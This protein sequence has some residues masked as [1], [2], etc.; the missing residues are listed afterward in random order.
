MALKP[1][2]TGR[3]EGYDIFVNGRQRTF[4]DVKSVAY[5][6]AFLLKSANKGQD[7][8]EIVDRATGQLMQVTTGASKPRRRARSSTKWASSPPHRPCGTFWGR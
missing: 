4:R 7:K 1:G 2:I 3:D 5:D 6:V 8:V